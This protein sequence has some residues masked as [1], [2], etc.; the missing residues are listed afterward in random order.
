MLNT[1]DN[2]SI[3]LALFLNLNYFSQYLV[4][5]FRIHK[6]LYEMLINPIFD[7]KLQ[8]LLTTI[9]QF[10]L[11]EAL[12]RNNIR[13]SISWQYLDD[14]SGCFIQKKM[15]S[16]HEQTRIELVLIIYSYLLIIFST[17][18]RVFL[19]ISMLDSKDYNLRTL[20]FLA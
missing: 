6:L 13:L 8:K 12:Q 2:Q 19:D 18:R 5:P 3:K 9:V 11:G 1:E 4:Y 15:A 16:S 14:N 10:K 20:S 17:F 7:D